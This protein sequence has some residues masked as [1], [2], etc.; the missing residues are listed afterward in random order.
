MGVVK[1][2]VKSVAKAVGLAPD[3]PQII[4][5]EAKAP[6]PAPVAAPQVA[7]AQP[8]AAAA[9]TAPTQGADTEAGLSTEQ[10]NRR[11][12]KALTIHRNAVG[13]GSGLNL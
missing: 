9:E 7:A 12:K 10:A 3:T 2:A 13:G 4:I 11:G 6:A 8:A 1:K 5:P